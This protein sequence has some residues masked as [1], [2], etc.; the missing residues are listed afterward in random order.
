MFAGGVRTAVTKAIAHDAH[1]I[2]T[3]GAVQTDDPGYSTHETTLRRRERDHHDPAG[4]QGRAK[5]HASAHE[6][7]KHDRQ[8]AVRLEGCSTQAREAGTRS[9]NQASPRTLALI[10]D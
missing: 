2:R 9:A 6:V 5:A 7:C 8:M 4:P 3:L 1:S 10:D